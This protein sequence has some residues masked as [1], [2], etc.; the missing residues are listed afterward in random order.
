MNEILS[1]D[2]KGDTPRDERGRFT[3]AEPPSEPTP[4][5]TP[6]EP[7][8]PVAEAPKPAEP[9]KAAEPT[10]APVTQEPKE[11]SAFKQAAIEERRKRQALEAEI[12]RLREQAQPQTPPRDFFENPDEAFEQRLTPKLREME[13]RMLD[14]VYNA[15]E[16]AARARYQDYDEKREMFLQL[17]QEDPTIVAGLQTAPDPAEYAYTTAKRLSVLREIGD[18]PDAYRKRVEAEIRERVMAEMAQQKPK[19][20]I[21]PPSS[22]NAE[23]SPVN[24][25]NWGGPTPIT[26]LFGRR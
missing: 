13:Q 22:L 17:A 10:P 2:E 25:Q 18:D 9:V 8:E 15:M 11:V 1:N 6:A 3:S 20:A 14:R 5:A 7:V 12:A 16:A 4:E 23:K 21:V 26:S 19:T 24:S